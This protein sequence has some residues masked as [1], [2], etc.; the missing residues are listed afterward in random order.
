[1]SE[2]EECGDPV[3]CN[4]P[5]V[6]TVGEIDKFFEKLMTQEIKPHQCV[7]CGKEYY[8]DS[9]GDHI[10]ECDE[11]WFSRFPKEERQAFY[12]SFFE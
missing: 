12:R 3:L 4:C 5:T 6:L 11:C 1:M 9:Y 10:G 8:F 7:K 2:C